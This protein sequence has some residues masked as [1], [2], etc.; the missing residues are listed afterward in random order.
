[1][2]ISILTERINKYHIVNGA[3]V[4]IAT[5]QDMLHFP[6][7]MAIASFICFSANAFASE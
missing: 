4:I 2:F 5:H 3:E 1:M 7:A 6:C